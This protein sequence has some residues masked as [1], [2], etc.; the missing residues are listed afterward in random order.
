MCFR[1]EKRESGKEET[2]R[3]GCMK[4]LVNPPEGETPGPQPCFLAQSY[5]ELEEAKNTQLLIKL[6]FLKLLIL[7]VF[8][9]FTFYYEH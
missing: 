6:D 3:L 4:L 1:V 9:I 8:L 2:P 7:R 5:S